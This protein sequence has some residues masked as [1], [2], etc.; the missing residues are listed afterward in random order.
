MRGFLV[1]MCINGLLVGCGEC[2]EDFDCP[3]VQACDTEEGTCVAL[4]C[5]EATDCPPAHDCNGNR[6]V[7]QDPAG[8]PPTPDAVVISP[9]G[10]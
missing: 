7:A 9:A 6:C 3:G 10:L 8:S 4:V 2:E 1:A 5:R